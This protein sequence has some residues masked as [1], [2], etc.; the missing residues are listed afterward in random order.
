MLV[1]NLT[2]TEAPAQMTDLFSRSLGQRLTAARQF[3]VVGNPVRFTANEKAAWTQLRDASIQTGL[4]WTDDLKT[5]VKNW[6]EHAFGTANAAVLVLWHR[7]GM[8]AG[9]SEPGGYFGPRFPNLGGIPHLHVKEWPRRHPDPS[10]NNLTK[11]VAEGFSIV[12]IRDPWSHVMIACLNP[13]PGPTGKVDRIAN[14]RAVLGGGRLDQIVG[15]IRPLVVVACGGEVHRALG[16][17]SAPS[18]MAVELVSHPLHWGG[19]A[20]SRHGPEVAR[21]LAGALD[22]AAA[23]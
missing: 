10:W 11:F 13:E 5:R 17:W 8:G 16:N 14:A 3:A 20:G 4:P 1:N 6:R 23:K 21:R 15:A 18:G 9:G 12:G 22:S 2:Y 7:P 19:F